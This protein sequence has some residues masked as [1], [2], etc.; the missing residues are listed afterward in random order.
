MSP[1]L[2]V[3]EFSPSAEV[4]FL[5]TCCATKASPLGDEPPRP[6]L[7]WTAFEA[8]ARRHGVLALVAKRLEGRRALAIE[9]I[10]TKIATSGVA[11]R[12]RNQYL[13]E[14]LLAL[15]K[16]FGDASIPVLII[17]G[18]VLAKL[19]YG[20]IGL[21]SF[22]DLDLLIR[23]GDIR[24]AA[25]L[26]ELSGLASENYC[27]EAMDAGF[28]CAVEA[29]FRTPDGTMRIDL[30]WRL[31]PSYYGFGPEG[32]ELWERAKDER[33]A[34]SPV[35]TLSGEDHLLYLAVHASRHGW[36]VL[37]QVCDIAHLVSRADLNWTAVL[38]RALRTGSHRMLAVGLLLARELCALELP[39]AA[40]E[41]VV[42][43]RRA[44]QNAQ[45]LS[46]R[47]ARRMFLPESSLRC[48]LDSIRLIENSNDRV[49]YIISSSVRPTLADWQWLQLPPWLYPA[50]YIVRTLRV[51]SVLARA[52]VQRGLNAFVRS[53][54]ST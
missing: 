50:Y 52:C 42:S 2:R 15:L 12:L 28:F 24:A 16:Q 40:I 26:L 21:R 31:S 53:S 17:K 47:I 7:D 38:E 14:R 19:A 49:H 4:E 1:I 23:P 46:S 20:D 36:P 8:L 10:A 48:W 25:R 51:V 54:H 41:R 5:L 43:H 35:R 45:L 30:H 3:A 27:D 22:S 6:G 32:D 39:Q 18:P 44:F 9:S 11:N 33:L 37:S 34:D 13:T 29:N